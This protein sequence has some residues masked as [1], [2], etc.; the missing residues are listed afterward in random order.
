MAQ[1]TGKVQDEYG[2]LQGALVTVVGT[3]TS[4]ETDAEG[5]FSIPGKVG[6]VLD[7][8]NPITFG[9]KTFP[10]KSLKMGVL[11]LNEKEVKLDVVVAFGKQKKENLSGAVSVVDSKVF[12]D[13][14]V[15]NAVEALQGQ[16]AGMNFN[17]GSTGTELGGSPEFNVRGKGTIGTGSNS[18]PLVLIDGMEGD[19]TSLNPQD[20]ES[21]SVLKD[22]AS[23]SIYGSRAAFGVILVTTK[24]GKEGK[25]SINY[26]NS[27]RLSTPTLLPKML[28]SETFANYFNDALSNAGGGKR[29]NPELMKKI[30]AYKNGQIEYETGW[31][32]DQL[33][34][35]IWDA[36]GNNNWYKI[37]YRDWAPSQEHN[38]SVNGGTANVNYYFSANYLGQE[39]LFKQNTDT[40][41]RYS[42]NGKFNAKLKDWLKLAYNSRFVREL[43]GKSSYIDGAR[44]DFYST[45]VKRWPVVPLK[46]SLGNYVNENLISEIN[47][48]RYKE[49]KDVLMQ[50]LNLTFTPAKNWNI[51][52][53]LSFKTDTR[54]AKR[55]YLPMYEYDNTGRPS[56][57]NP[58][59][60]DRRRYPLT[61]GTS[62]VEEYFFKAN[63]Y[64]PNIYTDYS[65]SFG[66]HNAK[67]MIGFQAEDYKNKAVVA[68]R[69]HLLAYNKPVLSLTDGRNT[70][71]YGDEREW[72]TAGFF[73]RLNYDYDGR[74]LLEFNL[75]YDGTSR[76]L[77]DQRWNWYPS[78][79]LGWNVAKENFWENLGGIF[80]KVNNFKLRASYGEL[81]NQNTSDYYPFYERM[82]LGTNNGQWLIDDY[83]TNTA[84]APNL[85]S[86]LLTWEKVATTNFGL[87]ITAFKNRLDFVLDV[88]QRKT[89]GMVGP[90]PEVPATLGAKVPLFNNTDMESK[91]FELSLGWNDKIGKDF[92]Y[93]I[94]GT[95]TDSKQ[96]VTNYPNETGSLETYYTGYELGTIWGFSTHGIA[97]TNQEMNEWL[98]THNPRFGS[99]W[100]A[101]D[102]MYNDLNG[103]GIIDD[104]NYTLDN[105]GDLKIIGNSTPRYNFGLE[106]NAQYKGFDF[107]AFF[108]GT[109][110]RDL[111]LDTEPGRNILNRDPNPM[112]SGANTPYRGSRDRVNQWPAVAFEQ[113]LDYFRPADTDSPFGP[114]VDAYYPAPRMGQS[115][116]NFRYP[117]TRFLQNGAYVRLKNIQL[118]YTLPKKLIQSVGLNKVRIYVSGENLVTWTKLSSIFDPEVVDGIYGKGM[119]YPLSKVISTGL[120]ISF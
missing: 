46:D 84:Y 3:N 11:K 115:Y 31:D 103:D 108:Q 67:V 107:R 116:K 106:L 73:G 4:V 109:A 94:K 23:S 26:N 120:S 53:N 96:K 57:A 79:S 83:F 119:M 22:A 89:K 72:S 58:R 47:M 70:N 91:G 64:S 56:F 43:N 71:V 90:A 118:G 36:W 68:E 51:Y 5:A 13:R 18:S 32:K 40:Y 17:V 99:D 117:Q 35:K 24:S 78:A 19:L 104:G 98:K 61:A 95:L 77:Q 110:K 9:Q 97:K 16:V 21:I 80:N 66:V 88:F 65:R 45:I 75:R 39:G 93:G 37:F 62:L 54:T 8:T 30:I 76:F 85:I 102:I 112:F 1:I 59:F 114:N 12:E 7:I 82:R 49:E 81:G 87:D 74:Y 44:G 105:H 86:G 38:L 20:I 113:H 34:W 33:K 55:Y 92:K 41:D 60:R 100:Q 29:F 69:D 52:A 48:G 63:Y 111:N 6:D 27:F 50:Q 42:V 14:P 25:V 2:P 101:G 15:S 10:V 28:D